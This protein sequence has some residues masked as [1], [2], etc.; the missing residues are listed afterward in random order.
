M[1]LKSDRKADVLIVQ[2]AH[3]EPWATDAT[4]VKLAGEL[5]RMAAWLGL[6]SLRVERRGDL[7]EALGK[8][9]A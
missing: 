1:D 8:A 2:S 9:L 7:A 5:K 4:P 3:A 6:E